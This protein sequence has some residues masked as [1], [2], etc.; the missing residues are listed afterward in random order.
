MYCVVS[1]RP[2]TSKERTRH[3]RTSKG[4]SPE[5][6][7]VWNYLGYVAE[8]AVA[9]VRE[10]HPD[11]GSDEQAR[12]GTASGDDSGGA[13]TTRLG[14]RMRDP[15]RATLLTSPSAA[16]RL[17]GVDTV[18]RLCSHLRPDYE[19]FPWYAAPPFC[20]FDY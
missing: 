4:A 1:R 13:V 19:M 8:M 14:P 3:E 10:S 5:E 17:L 16:T 7:Q 15:D 12:N 20:K 18:R 2:S 9:A 6:T 11:S